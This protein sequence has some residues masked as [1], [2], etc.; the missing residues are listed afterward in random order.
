MASAR[1]PTV[2]SILRMGFPRSRPVARLPA[3]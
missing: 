1:K 3:D 2:K